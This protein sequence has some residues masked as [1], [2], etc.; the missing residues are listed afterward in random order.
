MNTEATVPSQASAG[1]SSRKSARWQWVTGLVVAV[2]LGGATGM[3]ITIQGQSAKD[4]AWEHYQKAAAAYPKHDMPTVIAELQR[5]EKGVLIVH[6]LQ[7]GGSRQYATLRDLARKNATYAMS[8]AKQGE[9]DKALEM[10]DLNLAM[11]DQICRDARLINGLVAVAIYQLAGANRVDIYRTAGTAQEAQEE[12]R[13]FQMRQEAFKQR[14]K[15]KIDTFVQNN[16]TM[17]AREIASAEKQLVEEIANV[18]RLTLP[19]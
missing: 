16:A 13:Q 6:S 7:A 3:W 11:A 4:T 15:P 14:V 18:W 8:L 9:K 5:A 2:L 17:G 19:K 1:L 12:E 10:S